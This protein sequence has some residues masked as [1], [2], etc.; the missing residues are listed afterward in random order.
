MT[1]SPGAPAPR[2]LPWLLPAGGG[3]LLALGILWAIRPT[4]GYCWDGQFDG[5]CAGGTVD[6]PAIVGGVLLV[7]VYAALVVVAVVGRGPARFPL[8]IVGVSVLALM[9]VVAIL[10]SLAGTIGPQPI[11][12]Y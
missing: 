6:G 10:A 5:G 11:P 1:A 2:A 7:L 12:Y 4:W 9:A 3:V 8:L